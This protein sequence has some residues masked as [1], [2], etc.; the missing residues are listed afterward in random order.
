ML[1]PDTM[2]FIQYRLLYK[3]CDK[4]KL[5]AVF[6]VRVLQTS[7]ELQIDCVNFENTKKGSKS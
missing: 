4:R 6:V 2:I 5:E 1:I 7:D 3:E